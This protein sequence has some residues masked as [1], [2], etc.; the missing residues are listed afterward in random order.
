MKAKAYRNISWLILTAAMMLVILSVSTMFAQSGRPKVL[1][2]PPESSMDSK[3]VEDFQWELVKKLDDT[4]NFDVVEKDD[5]RDYLKK[6]NMVRETFIPKDMVP[7]MMDSLKAVIYT[8]GTL[9]QAGGEGTEVK[10]K[11]DFIFPGNDFSID[12]EEF[13]VENENKLGNLAKDVTQI[14]VKAAERIT[15][16]S[17]ARD[18]YNSQNY[19]KAIEYYTKLLD[20]QPDSKDYLYMKATCYLRMDDL[21]NALIYYNKLLNDV[22]PNHIPTHEILA[23]HYFANDN[24]EEALKHFSKLAEIDPQNY[25]Y[26]QY[27]VYALTK[28]ERED[29][30]LEGYEKL[31]TIKDEDASIRNQIGYI[32]YSKANTLDEK[33]DAEKVKELSANAV[34]HLTRAVELY[35]AQA[36][37]SSTE[38][39]PE[40]IKRINDCRNLLALSQMKGQDSEGALATFKA[41]EESDPAY[42]NL[43]YYLARLSSDMK[44]INDAI[45]YYNKAIETMPP[46]SHFSIYL[47]IGSLYRKVENY[48]GAIG[49]LTKAIAQKAD[50]SKKTTA[51]FLRGVSY[52][53][54]AQ[55]LDYSY[56]DDP[57]M[58]KLIERREMTMD[59]ANSALKYYDNAEGDLAKVTAGKYAKSAQQ[60]LA[61]ISQLRARVDK[62]KTQIQ[63]VLKTQ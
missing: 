28:L 46:S 45:G 15:N 57:D 47:T 59:K 11:I 50:A 23:K 26:L 38:Q 60:H 7:A 6:V 63:Y 29:E 25:E 22:D 31:I 30:A 40:D 4:G 5:Y 48:N 21:D 24:Y 9:E 14:L 51:L 35:V 42:P 8:W 36:D 18:Y 17:I 3:V 53:D 37:T 34:R 49:A 2:L 20:A 19:T 44:K 12:G 43:Y 16:M 1:V 62:I 58:N 41:I 13:T 32:Y 52:Y 33:T 56:M 27:K 61:N 55:Q 39:T 10:A 54:Q